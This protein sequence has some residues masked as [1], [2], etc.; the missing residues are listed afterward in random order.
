MKEYRFFLPPVFQR[1][2]VV[3]F[4][5]C[6]SNDRKKMCAHTNRGYTLFLSL[7]K[8]TIRCSQRYVR[9]GFSCTNLR[10]K[11]SFLHKAKVIFFLSREKSPL[12]AP[13]GM[14]SIGTFTRRK[15]FRF[16]RFKARTVPF[17]YVFAPSCV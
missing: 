11:R 15:F 12:L 16:S 1:I 2:L 7:H 10:E 9:A 4:S 14:A 13:S 17:G 5:S 3:E 8:I 6:C